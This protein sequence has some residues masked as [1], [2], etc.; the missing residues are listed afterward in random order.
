[1]ALAADR[2]LFRPGENPEDNQS[3]HIHEEPKS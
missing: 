3:Y 2:V 1:M